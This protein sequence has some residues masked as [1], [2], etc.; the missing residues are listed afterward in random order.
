VEALTI[1]VRSHTLAKDFPVDRVLF[2]FPS[3]GLTYD[4]YACGAL[5]CRGHGYRLEAKAEID[6]QLELQP[7]VGLFFADQED[8][9]GSTFTQNC[10]P[11]CFFLTEQGRCRVQAVKGYAAK[12]ETCRLFPFNDIRI[13]GDFLVVLPH[14]HLCPLG[15]DT[16][17]QGSDLSDH[18]RLLR[19]MASSPIKASPTRL[20]SPDGQVEQV[21]AIEA[22]MLQAV[23]HN[24][25]VDIS[26]F[27]Q[28]QADAFNV[29]APRSSPD[30][31]TWDVQSYS[32]QL[33]SVL[34][35]WPSDSADG[36]R[37]LAEVI[38]AAAPSLRIRAAV[39]GSRST[40]MVPP[41]DQSRLPLLLLALHKILALA[42]DAGMKVVTYQT[43]MRIF[44]SYQPLL[45]LLANL[46][47]VLAWHPHAAMQ[48]G[49]QPVNDSLR[50]YL[51]VARLLLPG[52][53]R[54]HRRVLSEVLAGC[55]SGGTTA[56]LHRL[57][58]LAGKLSGLVVLEH[59]L[60]RYGRVRLMPSV[61]R[62]MLRWFDDHT[63]L[64]MMNSGWTLQQ[65]A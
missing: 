33:R 47:Q 38:V 51:R 7:L 59:E 9:P 17:P 28:A 15:V 42:I 6:A 29:L 64:S 57:N 22:A 52:E 40:H 55:V 16:S 48:I 25:R 34:G 61:Q 37:Q 13:V 10:P 46:D 41:I 36:S 30:R 19:D 50:D 56:R 26:S 5:C 65:K 11:S 18:T 24:G 4:C 14:P 43:V 44:V 35:A 12:P 49:R 54:R 20:R 31:T 1:A 23:K 45:C 58:S 32:S 53:Q 8:R 39:A 3:R 63:L 62:A 60:H 2:G 27:V 21:M